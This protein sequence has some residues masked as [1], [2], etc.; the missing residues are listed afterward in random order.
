MGFK[1]FGQLIPRLLVPLTTYMLR[2]EMSAVILPGEDDKL[3]EHML[4]RRHEGVRVNLNHLGEAILGEEE[5][6]NLLALLENAQRTNQ[7]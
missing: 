7:N 5:A 4:R 1:W 2:R 3:K 6:N